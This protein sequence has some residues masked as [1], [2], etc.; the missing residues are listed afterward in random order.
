MTSIRHLLFIFLLVFGYLAF[1]SDAWAP[2]CCPPSCSCGPCPGLIEGCQNYCIC[3]S[4]AETGDS[5]DPKTTVGHIT[6]EFKKHRKWI[7]DAFFNDKNEGDPVGLLAA[8]KLMTDQL[9]ASGMQQ[10]QMVGAFFD[11]K[12]QLETQRIMQELTARAHKD[13]QPSQDMCLT[14]TMTRSLSGSARQSDLVQVGLANWSLQRQ[15][16]T[17]DSVGHENKESDENSRLDQFIKK[18][19]NP[20][21]NARNLDWLC[22]KSAKDQEYINADVNYT[23]T[24]DAPLTLDLDF[25]DETADN[26]TKQEEALFALKANLFSHDLMPFV[27]ADKFVKPNGK[28][29]DR[30]ADMDY[31]DFR[32]LTAKRSVAQNSIASIAAL[33]AKGDTNVKPFIYS[34]YEQLG[35]GD[36][37]ETEIEK[38][39]GDKPSY[40]AQMEVLSKKL[41]Q[42]PEFYAELYD[43][44]ANV[45]RKNVALQAVT[46]MQKR[47][48]YRSYLRSEMTLAVMLEVALKKEHERVENEAR[49]FIKQGQSAPRKQN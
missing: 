24:V 11:A 45:L 42:R 39:I 27:Q 6:D 28:P 5:G 41:Y 33:K 31:L 2:H 46:L 10:T 7:E 36:I 48:L 17:K 34:L 21:D 9:V 19:C 14:G 44:P 25:Y 30:A 22:K 38:I 37:E 40:Y 12:H 16:M 32:A 18:Y 13:Y 3:V 49:K 26:P 29:A 8:M 1:P 20:D 4:T 23:K 15:M 47:D 35:G 43:K